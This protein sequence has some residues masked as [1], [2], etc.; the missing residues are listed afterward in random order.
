MWRERTEGAKC[1]RWCWN[2]DVSLTQLLS[3]LVPL[4]VSWSV[5]PAALHAQRK[6]SKMKVSA[7]VSSSRR[8][9]R[10]AHFDAPSHIRARLL[11]A[12]LSKE[13]RAKYNVRSLPVRKD[14]EVCFVGG[15]DVRV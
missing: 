3:T 10:K 15:G 2:R 5:S 11:S 8:K 14:D 1:E 6:P 9:S 12:P 7:N 4:S 13:L